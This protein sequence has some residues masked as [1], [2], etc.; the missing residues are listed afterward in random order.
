[1]STKSFSLGVWAVSISVIVPGAGSVTVTWKQAL[2]PELHWAVMDVMDGVVA[3]TGAAP[4]T[5]SAMAANVVS[6]LAKFKT[7]ASPSSYRRVGKNL[8]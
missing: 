1:V 3:C 5:A 7:H 6:A 8:Q 4:S 2:S